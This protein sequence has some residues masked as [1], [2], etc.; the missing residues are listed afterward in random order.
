MLA[1]YK[2]TL[3]PRT[4]ENAEPIARD[5]L[6]AA[7]AQLGF[8]PNMYT[9]MANSPGLLSTYIHGYT[10][11]R[12]S[13]GFTP[14]EQEVVF[15]VISRANGCGYCMAAHSFV[16]DAM[17]R[18]PMAVT[19][20]IRDDQ[21]IADPKLAALAL[22]TGVMFATRGLPSRSD[23]EAFLAAG[24]SENHMLDVVLAIA[25]K[26]ISN[27]SN[28]LFHTPVDLAFAGRVWQD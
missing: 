6:A 26:T 7:Q 18:V 9:T 24:Y 8:I 1:E 27:Y 4:I 25:V 23:V 15:L 21:A 13:S 19:N 20:A 12:H 3:P 2:L 5:L 14:V 22:F 17:S 10:Q 11:L 16:A 28:H